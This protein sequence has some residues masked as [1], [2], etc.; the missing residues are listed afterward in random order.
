MDDFCSLSLKSTQINFVCHLMKIKSFK[1]GGKTAK[2]ATLGVIYIFVLKNLRGLQGV[3]HSPRFHSSQPRL[4]N[5]CY[6]L[7]VIHLYFWFFLR[8]V[9]KQIKMATCQCKSNKNLIK[10]LAIVFQIE[11]VYLA[12][13][14]FVVGAAVSGGVGQTW[15]L[16]SFLLFRRLFFIRFSGN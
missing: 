11:C 7:S 13:R 3:G 2:L 8:F 5:Y 6:T 12:I 16:I 10:L 15:S 1:L 14:S 9:R 4:L